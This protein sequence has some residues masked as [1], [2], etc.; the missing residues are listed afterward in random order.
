[1]TKKK[2]ISSHQLTVQYILDNA[3]GHVYWKN[4]K[5][6]FLGCNKQQAKSFGLSSPL[7]KL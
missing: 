3:P 1:M 7:K 5:G 4:S 6:E 2:T